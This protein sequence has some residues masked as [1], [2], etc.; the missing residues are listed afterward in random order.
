MK[1]ST[2]SSHLPQWFL[3]V[4]LKERFITFQCD[5][6]LKLII[7]LHCQIFCLFSRLAKEF[8]IVHFE[9]FRCISSHEIFLRSILQWILNVFHL[10]LKFDQSHF[11]LKISSH[12]YSSILQEDYKPD[13]NERQGTWF[14]STYRT[15]RTNLEWF[16]HSSWWSRTH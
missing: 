4:F 11:F 14:S 6:W 12:L 15:I 16:E 13:Y 5:L 9:F 10:K 2:C 8:L 3:E 7:Q 1:L